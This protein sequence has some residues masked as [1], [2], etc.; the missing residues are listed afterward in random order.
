MHSEEQSPMKIPV[1]QNILSANPDIVAV[2]VAWDP[3]A[4]AALSVIRDKGLL[5]QITLVKQ[6]FRCNHAHTG[7]GHQPGVKLCTFR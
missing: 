1:V 5:D 3:G 6:F 2:F 7:T 4:I